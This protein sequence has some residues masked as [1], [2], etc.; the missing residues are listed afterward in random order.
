MI[1]SIVIQF[2][3]L[4]G[5]LLLLISYWRENINKIL[6]IQLFS[7][8]FYIVHY[9][10]LGAYSALLVLSLEL[11]RDFLY[12][13]TNLDRYIFFGTIPFYLAFSYFSFSGIFS[14][15]PI[16]SSIIDGYGLSIRKDTAVV[17]AMISEFLWLIYDAVC[18]SYVGIVSGVI[19][20][21]SEFLVFWK[22][23]KS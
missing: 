18:G 20:L 23:R 6:V 9:Y 22:E 7:G 21:L 13:K 15:F 1:H 10:C 11:V 14:L 3:G 19:L 8:L 16:F 4:V 5:F 2:F 17:G 12:Y